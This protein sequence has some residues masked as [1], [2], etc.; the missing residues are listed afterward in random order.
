MAFVGFAYYE[1]NKD[2]VKAV[3]IDHGKGCVLPSRET[4]LDGTYQ[5][6]S[7]P[8][9]IY[10]NVKSLDR[11]EVQAFVDFYLSPAARRAIRSTGYVELPDEAYRIGQGLVARKKTGSFFTDL[12]PGTP[13]PSSLRSCG[14]KCSSPADPWGWGSFP[15]PLE[16]ERH[17]DPEAKALE[18]PQGGAHLRPPGLP[19]LH[20]PPHHPGGDPEPG[21]GRG[22]VLPPGAPHGVPLRPRVDPLFA[23]PR[24]GISPLIAGTFLVT[25]IALLVAVPLGLALAIYLSEYASGA[26]R[27]RIKGTLELFEGIPT[28]VFGYFAL[29][30]VTPCCN[31][32]SLT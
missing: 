23:D 22:P 18:E 2:K 19:L 31:G 9:F 29:L 7:R 25:L 1:E 30:F 8:L 28:V 21:R 32:S 14:R 17:G 10:V 15:T 12:P 26:A 20:H 6:L 4:V 24:Y 13:W 5:P 27:A 11:P 16:W 3:A